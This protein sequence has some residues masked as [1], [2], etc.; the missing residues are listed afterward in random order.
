MSNSAVLFDPDTGSYA[1]IIDGAL[2]I[3]LAGIT[4]AVTIT[5]KSNAA[6]LSNVASSATNVT[7]LAANTNR[8][9]AIIFNDSTANLFLKFGA[10]AST[11]SFTAK[12]AAGASFT[13]GA[14]ILYAGIIEGI[15]DAANGNA[16]ITE[17]T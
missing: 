17:L 10:T 12:L 1:S 7:L 9:G 6:T 16:R 14:D 4:N 2:K 3:A 5:P 11:S 13:I 15:W 8:K